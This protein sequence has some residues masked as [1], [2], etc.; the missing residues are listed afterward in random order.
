MVF[1]K[2]AKEQKCNQSP[3]GEQSKNGQDQERRS[4]W[5]GKIIRWSDLHPQKKRI[6]STGKEMC[7]IS[8]LANRSSTHLRI[9]KQQDLLHIT[10]YD[11]NIQIIRLLGWYSEPLCI[12]FLDSRSICI[13]SLLRALNHSWEITNWKCQREVD[14][15]QNLNGK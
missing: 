13:T 4:R 6:N 8:W 12:L 1:L 2:P 7:G 11:R 14:R 10:E 15:G 5:N 9:Y 3:D